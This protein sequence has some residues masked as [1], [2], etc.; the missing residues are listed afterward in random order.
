MLFRS[1]ASFFIFISLAYGVSQEAKQIK[2]YYP[3]LAR[4]F[5]IYQYVKKKSTPPEDAL[6][7]Y[8]GIYRKT[9]RLKRVF[10]KKIKDKELIY[11]SNCKNCKY[12]NI[13]P[14]QFAKLGIKKQWEKYQ[15]LRKDFSKKK[16]FWL[17]AMMAKDTF[18]ALSRGSGKEYLRVFNSVDE[19]YKHKV[20]DKKMAS[21][22]FNSSCQQ[23]KIYFFCFTCSYGWKL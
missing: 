2:S 9:S 14:K 20:L 8:D 6:Y 11:P 4:D 13:N 1:I 7:L 23:E 17:R 12:L 18:K 21:S 3:S 15:K 16:L 19:R 5:L 22:F 10:F